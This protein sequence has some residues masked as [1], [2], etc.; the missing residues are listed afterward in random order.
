M[1][2]PA[3]TIC[4]NCKTACAELF[5]YDC[6]KF[7]EAEMQEA[8]AAVSRCAIQNYANYFD[9]WHLFVNGY[10]FEMFEREI[11][12]NRITSINDAVKFY[13]RTLSDRMSESEARRQQM[14][15]QQG[16]YDPDSNFDG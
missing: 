15:Y 13:R 5:C 2:A 1:T 4:L 8:F 6:V 7:D 12:E 3:N 16:W 9:G 11:H 14:A 10:S